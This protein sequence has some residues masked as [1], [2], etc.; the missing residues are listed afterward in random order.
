MRLK[1]LTLATVLMVA[2]AGST[3]AT[4][5]PLGINIT[6]TDGNAVNL[7][8]YRGIGQGREDNET[9]GSPATYQ[10]Q[11]WDVEGLFLN[12][13][14]LEMIGGFK[15]DTGVTWNDSHGHYGS[16]D[17]FFRLVNSSL[18]WDYAIRLYSNHT[19]DVL[20]LNNSTTFLQTL[21]SDVPSSSPWRVNNNYQTLV[22][23]KPYGW[24]TLT[25]AE[26]GFSSWT[27]NVDSVNGETDSHWLPGN[28]PH[29]IAGGGHNHYSVSGMDL[30]FLGSN[31]T[32][33]VH[34]TMECGNDLI[35][36]QG[37][38][39]VPEPASFLLLGIGLGGLRW[40]RRQTKR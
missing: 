18:T 13:N 10:S 21:A 23:G 24:G 31:Q 19:Y 22:S 29:F 4:A 27:S 39:E 11:G 8:G 7:A 12:G 3:I 9:E 32:F 17:I 2:F 33:D 38:T 26:S 14:M 30:S 34:F 1:L 16:G 28:S 35:L 15:F 20:A 5:T 6:I 40:I 36:G 25:D 37:T